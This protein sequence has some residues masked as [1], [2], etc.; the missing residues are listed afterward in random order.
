[1]PRT[2]PPTKPLAGINPAINCRFCA[3][4][5]KGGDVN[6]DLFVGGAACPGF[7]LAKYIYCREKSH[8]EHWTVCA[9]SHYNDA[10]PCC[11]SCPVGE[12]MVEVALA[13]GHE[14]PDKEN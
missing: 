1:M 3:N 11:E 13:T 14:I 7:R 4:R 12:G 5:T 2:K 6:S 10:H 8:F 9:W